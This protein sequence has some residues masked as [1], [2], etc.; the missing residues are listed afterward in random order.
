MRPLPWFSLIALVAC[1]GGGKD[2]PTP[3]D[4]TPTPPTTDTDDTDPP[5]TDNPLFDH[6]GDEI[7][8]LDGDCDDTDPTIYPGADD[9][10]YDG[11]DSDCAGDDDY[12][13][14]GDG[15]RSDA[16]GGTDCDDTDPLVNPD[17]DEVCNGY[18]DD[19]DTLVDGQGALDATLFYPDLDGDGWGVTEGVVYDCLAPPDHAQVPGD[20]DDT[21]AD[22]FPGALAVACDGRD[23]DCNPLTDEPGGEVR[24]L[25][26]GA[27][28]A[29]V[30]SALAAAVAGDEIEICDGRY[31]VDHLAI[32]APITLR[33]PGT[34]DAVV[35]DAG[36]GSPVLA[37]ATSAPVTLQG[38]TLED[39]LGLPGAGV[40]G[41]PAGGGLLLAPG[42]DLTLVDVVVQGSRAG[43]GGGMYLY[44]GATLTARGLSVLDNVGDPALTVISD[45]GG[46]WGGDG[47][48]LDLQDTVIDGN[49]ADVCGGIS[50]GDD[51]VILGAGSTRVSANTASL[52]GGGLC[53]GFR[54]ELSGLEVREN[55]AASA[56]G[57]DTLGGTIT[58]AVF[59]ENEASLS[60]GGISGAGPLDLLRVEVSSNVAGIEGGGLDLAFSDTHAVLTD[61]VVQG[62]VTPFY[63]AYGGGASLAQARLESIDTDWG[64]GLVDNSPADI[65]LI[66]TGTSH[67]WVGVASF[68]CDDELGTCN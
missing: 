21:Q 45:G 41:E 32:L 15:D 64:T 62:N 42:G 53:V 13:A 14:D 63:G 18:D 59:A 43:T 20:C 68:V 54:G 51:A 30:A 67:T 19:C 38:L 57:L 27:T 37:I 49:S 58:D 36:G 2:D 25:T 50:L 40:F 12:D 28:H 55:T 26:S 52:R 10:P 24:N 5:T 33:G 9:P 66:F 47:V 1:S 44:D 39:G 11:I 29:D 4:P 60:G 23:N 6:D 35:L 7:S 22:T 56:G 31:A 46:L 34:A 3:T 8:V 16:H 65:G 48:T 61:C 17:A